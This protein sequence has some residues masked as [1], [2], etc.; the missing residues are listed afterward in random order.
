MKESAF[1][2]TVR[3]HLSPFGKLVRIENPTEPGTAD[4]FYSLRRPGRNA[5]AI[6]WFELKSVDAFPARPSTP[7]RI[8]HLTKEQADFARDWSAIGVPVHM[9]LRAPPWVL[10]F[11]ARGIRGV[12]GRTVTAGDAPAVAVVAA[13]GKFPTGPILRRLCDEGP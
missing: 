3:T 2:S 5:V 13:R 8:E 7:L 10:M 1:W 6:G 4:V 11:D 12:Y 9:L